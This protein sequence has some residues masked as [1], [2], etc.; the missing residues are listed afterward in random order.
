MNGWILGPDASEFTYSL[1]GMAIPFVGD[2][3]YC[4][5]DNEDYGSSDTA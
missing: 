2:S 5:Q 3:R 1:C 4:E